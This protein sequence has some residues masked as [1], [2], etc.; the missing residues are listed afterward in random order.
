MTGSI[1]S[2]ES[3]EMAQKL[4][5][6]AREDILL[7]ALASGSSVAEAARLAAMSAR[8]V[9]RRLNDEKFRAELQ[10]V[11]S[12]LIDGSLARLV[13]ALDTAACTLAELLADSRPTVR[14]SAA[15]SMFEIVC[16]L[17]EQTEFEE[18]LSKLEESQRV[19]S[20][21]QA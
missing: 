15:R 20:Q 18:R 19:Q 1:D 7:A 12:R 5:H 13:G 17:R 8:S 16:R 11:R 2:G 4:G 14:L 9:H 10:Q 3:R 21:E 6:K